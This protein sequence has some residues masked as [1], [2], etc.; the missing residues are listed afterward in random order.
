MLK[1]YLS[2]IQSRVSSLL[3]QTRQYE[4]MMMTQKLAGGP[5]NFI[6]TTKTELEDILYVQLAEMDKKVMQ[7]KYRKKM[8]D[9]RL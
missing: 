7:Q 5:T 4:N 9:H 1:Q 3:A 6:E 2:P 8:R